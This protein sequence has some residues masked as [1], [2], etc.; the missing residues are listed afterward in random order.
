MVDER[1][2]D[3]WDARRKRRLGRRISK[4]GFVMGGFPL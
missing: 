1:M 4:N 2:L 3:L